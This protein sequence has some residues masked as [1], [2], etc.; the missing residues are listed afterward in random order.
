MQSYLGPALQ[1]VPEPCPA[2]VY[3]SHWPSA[4]FLSTLTPDL[5]CPLYSMSL[6]GVEG[7]INRPR[8]TEI[9]PVCSGL[10]CIYCRSPWG[11][12]RRGVYGS[13]LGGSAGCVR[14]SL[15]ISRKC[16]VTRPRWEPSQKTLPQPGQ[17]K[18][19][20]RPGRRSTPAGT[21]ASCSRVPLLSVAGGLGRRSDASS[22]RH[23]GS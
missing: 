14:G 4:S 9:G 2:L 8:E 20:C 15:R 19:W 12:Q 5:V 21:P 7:A 16:L 23:G 10:S 18:K 1:P 6:R 22:Q 13:V 11:T 17:Q 3:P